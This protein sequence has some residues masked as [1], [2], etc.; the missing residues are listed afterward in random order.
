MYLWEHL[1]ATA[2]VNLQESSSSG[3]CLATRPSF[4]ESPG[5]HREWQRGAGMRPE[6]N[7]EVLVP[8]IHL[9]AISLGA[10]CP[11]SANVT[12]WLVFQ[13]C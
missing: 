10:Q 12:A 9:R 6:D 5:Q 2:E 4:T 7:L 8:E 1:C 11:N 3:H 13:N